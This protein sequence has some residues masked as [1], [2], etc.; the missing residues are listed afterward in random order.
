MNEQDPI[1]ANELNRRINA[2]M[3]GKAKPPVSEA[4]QPEAELAAKLINLAQD[5][6]PDP[7]FVTNLGS[8]LAAGRQKTTITKQSCAARTAVI[9]AAARTTIKGRNHHES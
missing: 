7:D 9:L 6:H 8:Q 3:Q 1:L 5:T 4:I 2:E